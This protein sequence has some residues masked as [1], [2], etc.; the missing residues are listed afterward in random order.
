MQHINESPLM[1]QI[2]DRISQM[3]SHQER[4]INNTNNNEGSSKTVTIQNE[5]DSQQ[6]MLC[7][8]ERI[9]DN[10]I[11]FLELQRRKSTLRRVKTI[12]NFEDFEEQMMD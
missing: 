5:F 10:M 1:S 2:I 11:E 9:M 4:T 8:Q 7:I 6:N 12:Q 3:C